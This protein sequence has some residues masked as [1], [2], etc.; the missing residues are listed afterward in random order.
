MAL[1]IRVERKAKP[2]VIKGEIPAD[3]AGLLAA[4]APKALK[5]PDYELIL[6]DPE[7]SEAEI[8]VQAS[9]AR[10]WGFQQ[11]PQ[12]NV[13]RIANHKGMKDNEAR[14]TVAL[15]SESKPLGRPPQTPAPAP[16]PTPEPPATGKK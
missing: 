6:F 8:K 9:Y 11:D 4:E 10:A 16:E 1:S 5:D 3:L 14:L 15:L 12:L 2:G 7:L 13:R